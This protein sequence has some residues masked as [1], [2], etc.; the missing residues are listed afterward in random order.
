MDH[1]CMIIEADECSNPIVKET[2]TFESLAVELA[3]KLTA[4]GRFEHFVIHYPATEN[5]V[6]HWK[7]CR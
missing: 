1:K 2:L 3:N 6:E 5:N 4:K 7:V